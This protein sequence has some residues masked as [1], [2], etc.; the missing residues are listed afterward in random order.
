MIDRIASL[1]CLHFWKKI[2]KIIYKDKHEE[3]TERLKFNFLDKKGIF[4]EF[5]EVY[6]PI[7]PKESVDYP[8]SAKKSFHDG[9]LTT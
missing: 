1:P 5:F 2:K 7:G 6:C 8:E 9:H 3:C 4:N